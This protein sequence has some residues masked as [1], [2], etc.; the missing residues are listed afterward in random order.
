MTLPCLLLNLRV[1]RRRVR[2]QQG[3][4]TLP[5][6][7]RKPARGARNII[8]ESPKD[9]PG[10]NVFAYRNSTRRRRRRRKMKGKYYFGK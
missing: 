4:P 10:M 1:I 6:Q 2:S 8:P 9:I 5:H 3:I 7:S